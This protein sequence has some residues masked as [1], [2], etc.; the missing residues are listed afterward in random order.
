M[1]R[2][3]ILVPSCRIFTSFYQLN[4]TTFDNL[5]TLEANIG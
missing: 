3:G 2:S 1:E 5:H 4:A